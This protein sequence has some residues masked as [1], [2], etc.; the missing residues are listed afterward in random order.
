MLCGTRRGYT[1]L[2][3]LLALAGCDEAPGNGSPADGVP[4]VVG[5]APADSAT[6]RPDPA[7]S[8]ALAIEGDGLRVFVVSTG[9]ARPIPFGTSAHAALDVLARVQGEPFERSE[10]DDCAIVYASW[11]DGLTIWL[12]RERFVGWS[13]RGADAPYST[14]SGIGIGSTRAELAG[15]Y[16]VKIAQTSLGTEFTAGGLAGVLESERMDA[17]ITHL[18][19]GATCIA[20]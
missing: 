9:S 5:D 7:A 18:W 16:D 17:R 3:A 13:V 6:A 8:A 14:A 20:R 12:Q 10:N 15:A 19:A 2:I 11:R 4:D 1:C